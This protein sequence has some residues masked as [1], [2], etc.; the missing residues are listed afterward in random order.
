MT[1]AGAGMPDTEQD[2]SDTVHG[3]T[4]TV[5]EEAATVPDDGATPSPPAPRERR[6]LLTRYLAAYGLP[7]LTLLVGVFFSVW[8]KTSPTF[9]TTANLQVLLGTQTV[10]AVVAIGALIPLIANEWDLSVGAVAG[11]AAV[12][13]AQV[14]SHGTNPVVAVLAGLGIGALVGLANALIVTR[15]RVNTVITTL[16]MAT[17][18]DGLVNQRTQGVAVTSDIPTSLTDFG[19][20]TWLGLPRTVYAVAVIALAVY[21][22]LGHTPFGRYLYA[23][24]SNPAA[25]EL[26][27]IR[28]R[29]VLSGAFVLAG[30]LAA[31]GGFLQVAR[32]GGAD[33]H[34]GDGFTL[35]ALAAAFLSAA[36]IRPGKYNIG[37]AMVALVFLA[38]VNSGLNL[39]GTPAYV[40]DYVNG[41]ALILGVALSGWLARRHGAPA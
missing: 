18:I 23:L 25:A 39:A 27:G 41:S 16:G 12:S 14:M 21:Y 38:V 40:A 36:S 3:A 37:G 4:S 22:L 10:V 9:L 24:G 34:V 33:P 17:V 29:T 20:G 32:S 35:P 13:S 6:R 8:P 2:G 19:T 5:R 1:E 11:L 26:V 28:V 15:A 7:L 30:V 31:A